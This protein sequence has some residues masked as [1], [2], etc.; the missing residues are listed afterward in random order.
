VIASER[1]DGDH[2]ITG[3]GHRIGTAVALMARSETGFALAGLPSFPKLT[4]MWALR[5]GEVRG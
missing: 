2:A 3:A 5:D 4:H 1:S